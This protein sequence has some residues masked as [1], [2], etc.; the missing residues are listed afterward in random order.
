MQALLVW[1]LPPW[2]ML[3]CRQKESTGTT[4]R[5]LNLGPLDQQTNVQTIGLPHTCA[6]I[7]MHAHTYIYIHT[8]TQSHIATLYTH[9]ATLCT[10]T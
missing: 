3:I 2:I 5:A 9:V 7:I 10:N 4:C 1:Y 8:Y 6:H